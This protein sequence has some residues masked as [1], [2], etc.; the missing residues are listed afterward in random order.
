MQGLVR[1]AVTMRFC[2]KRIFSCLITMTTSLQGLLRCVWPRQRQLLCL[3]Q[4]LKMELT[5]DSFINGFAN[6]IFDLCQEKAM[7]MATVSWKHSLAG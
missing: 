3:Q 6:T 5:K 2:G 7:A 4:L 1:L